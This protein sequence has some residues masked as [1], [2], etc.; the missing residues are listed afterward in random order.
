MVSEI[1][2]DAKDTG[3]GSDSLEDAGGAA[4]A[5]HDSVLSVPNAFC[6]VCRSMVTPLRT[7]R[8]NSSFTIIWRC[9]RCGRELTAL[10]VDFR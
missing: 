4:A 8:R 3:F 2:N 10:D 5:M 6:R 9:S 1:L 7:E